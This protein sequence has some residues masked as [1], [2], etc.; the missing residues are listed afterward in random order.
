M[1]QLH[2]KVIQ[3]YKHICIIFEIIFCHV[4]SHL[5]VF[6]SCNPV[7]YNPPDTSVHGD[8]PGKNTG[9]DCHFLLWFA[10]IGYY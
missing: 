4:L 6:N 7:D 5:V 8:S 1:F 2:S 3:L 10:I 9:V